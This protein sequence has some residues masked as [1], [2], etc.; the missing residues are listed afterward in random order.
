M[1]WYD[2]AR[3][4]ADI[5]LPLQSCHTMSQCG[6]QQQFANDDCLKYSIQSY[7]VEQHNFYL[8]IVI[9]CV[10]VNKLMSVML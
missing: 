6:I 10:C 8:V 5:L 7:T 3:P 2:E 1:A 9:G 4:F